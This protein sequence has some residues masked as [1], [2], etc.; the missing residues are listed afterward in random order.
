MLGGC[1]FQTAC[2]QNM[3]ATWQLC[4][5]KVKMS[6]AMAIQQGSFSLP[7]SSHRPGIQQGGT[8]QLENAFGG[9]LQ[10]NAASNGNDRARSCQA[11]E[12]HGD[13]IDYRAA[14]AF[15]MLN[16]TAQTGVSVTFFC[17]TSAGGQRWM[18]ANQYRT[19]MKEICQE[20]GAHGGP[21]LA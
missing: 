3:A 19:D 6:P 5:G 18:G 4:V 11:L 1:I 13:C 9:A 21:V 15:W 14:E 16:A 17:H 12:L 20:K 8:R 10:P 7:R 2:L